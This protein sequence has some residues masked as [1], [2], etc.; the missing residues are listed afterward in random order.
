MG[1]YGP[2]GGRIVQGGQSALPLV[3][4]FR[5]RRPIGIISYLSMI[6]VANIERQFATPRIA[7]MNYYIGFHNRP[8]S[9][10]SAAAF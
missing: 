1:N 2:E 10:L 7:R 6:G 5:V 9:P 8:I 3:K 4:Y